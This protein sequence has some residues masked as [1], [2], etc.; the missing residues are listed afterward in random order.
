MQIYSDEPY[1]N[2][3]TIEKVGL[4]NRTGDTTRQHS[5]AQ[6]QYLMRSIAGCSRGCAIS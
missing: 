1:G 2:I 5:L 4:A 3:V 6:Q